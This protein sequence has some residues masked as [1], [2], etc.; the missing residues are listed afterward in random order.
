M[1]D[2]SQTAAN[3]AIGSANASTAR[4]QFG[5]G[6]TQGQPVYLNTDA[7]YYRCD[8]NDTLAKAACAGIVLTPASTN[9]Y[10]I[11]VK[12]GTVNG[13]TLVNLGATLVVGTAYGVSA[14][15][16]AICPIADITTTQ[17]P[18]II[19]FAVTTSLLDFQVIKCSVAKA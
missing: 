14:T 13:D 7:K 16:G 5:E 18:T 17:F 6:V 9:G 12:P 15:L 11:I 2:L 3:V 19:G 1:A 10:G 8:A 4:V